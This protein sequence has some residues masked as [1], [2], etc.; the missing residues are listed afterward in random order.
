MNLYFG[1]HKILAF[2]IIN[3]F[4]PSCILSMTTN[5]CDIFSR[6]K[7]WKVRRALFSSTWHAHIATVP[8]KPKLHPPISPLH[9]HW[10]SAPF[11][12]ILW[13]ELKVL[14]VYCI[15]CESCALSIPKINGIMQVEYHPHNFVVLTLCP[16]HDIVHVCIYCFDFVEISR[17][18]N[19]LE[20]RPTL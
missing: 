10:I 14:F 17:L 1:N 19:L 18:H 7:L 9:V 20:L 6:V 8:E 11:S 5:L 2:Y 4:G 15:F 16:S 3:V 12:A 13:K